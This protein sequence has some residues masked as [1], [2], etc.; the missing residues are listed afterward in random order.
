AAQFDENDLT[1]LRLELGNSDLSEILN[2]LNALANT[3]TEVRSMASVGDK[4]KSNEP[5]NEQEK[6]FFNAMAEKYSSP[7][8]VNA[9]RAI[10]LKD[11]LTPEDY[12]FLLN[13]FRII[14]CIQR[15]SIVKYYEIR[16]WLST[17]LMFMQDEFESEE[18]FKEWCR[19]NAIKIVAFAGLQKSMTMNYDLPEL[20]Y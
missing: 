14:L 17:R 7:E 20:D 19:V 5:L 10:L 6:E 16:L 15:I 1:A 13:Q 11:I 12:Q 9:I 18:D 2:N 4:L 3:A 8:T